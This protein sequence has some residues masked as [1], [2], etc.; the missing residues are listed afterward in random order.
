VYLVLAQHRD[1]QAET[2]L[3]QLFR[4]AGV[5]GLSAMPSRRKQIAGIAPQILRPLL[6]VSRNNIEIYAKQQRLRWMHDERNDSTLFN[7]NF[8]RHKIFPLLRAKYPGYA[9]ALPR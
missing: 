9:Q 6:D 5:R 3:L 4:G 2:L 1:D 8:L 7:R